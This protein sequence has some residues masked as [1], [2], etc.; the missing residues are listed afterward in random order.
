MGRPRGS[1]RSGRTAEDAKA[2]NAA[3]D[4]VVLMKFLLD[5]CG[6]R[7]SLVAP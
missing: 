2:V 3:L 4:A 1:A 6:I 5:I 7:G